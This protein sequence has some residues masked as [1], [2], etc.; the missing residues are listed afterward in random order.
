MLHAH[1]LAEV[2]TSMPGIGVR[3]GARILLEVGDAATFPTSGDPAAYAGLA[4]VTRRSG[5]SIR[6]EHPLKGGNKQLKRAF[7]LAAFA[8]LAHPPS[9]AYYDRKRAEGKKHNA[10][11]I[12]LARR[13]V[14]VPH[15]MLRTKTTYQPPETAGPGT[16]PA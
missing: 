5:S 11:L 2:L 8:S 15:A 10:A 16:Q 9:R 7:F 14:D 12:C 1:P 6:G 4:P 3:T 13:R